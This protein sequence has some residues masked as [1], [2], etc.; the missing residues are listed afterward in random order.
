MRLPAAGLGFEQLERS[1]VLQ[2]L[3]HARWNKAHAAR[4]L[5]MP[6]DWLRYRIE[7][8]DLHPPDSV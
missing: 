3:E 2:A 4:L 1:L 8:F 7:K 5:G 6:R